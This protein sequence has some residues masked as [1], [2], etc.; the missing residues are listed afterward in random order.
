MIEEIKKRLEAG[1][2]VELECVDRGGF[3]KDIRRREANEKILDQG[4]LVVGCID[5]DGDI[6]LVGGIGYIYRNVIVSGEFKY[7]R[8]KE[9]SA[10]FDDLIDVAVKAI[11]DRALFTMS[12][13]NSRRKG[14]YLNYAVNGSSPNES[15]YENNGCHQ[16]AINFINSLY[17]ET[18][19]IESE[20]D[21]NKVI[22]RKEIGFNRKSMS[23]ATLMN[24]NEI[25]ITRLDTDNTAG[26][27]V[28]MRS[29]LYKNYLGIDVLKGATVTQKRGK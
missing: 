19:V 10:T 3:L 24:G 12:I 8:I 25:L 7:F 13:G 4:P 26:I 15:F 14:R 21:I 11:K 29:G 16:S 6:S 23:V 22:S 17:T 28:Y 27:V 5:C 2:V 9:S 18:F 1:E 20:E